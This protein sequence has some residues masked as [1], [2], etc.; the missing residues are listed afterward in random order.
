MIKLPFRLRKLR[1]W[2]QVM[3]PSP[4]SRVMARA[5]LDSAALAQ[6]PI[7]AY[8]AVKRVPF[9]ETP[10]DRFGMLNALRSRL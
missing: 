1:V 2:H 7:V 3:W 8:A 5:R 4:A 9:N 6:L 10:S